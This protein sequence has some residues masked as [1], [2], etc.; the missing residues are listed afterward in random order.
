[1]SDIISKLCSDFL[2]ECYPQLKA[3]H[4]REL[5]A[6]FFGYNSHAALLA[7]KSNSVEFLD[8]AAVLIPDRYT[9]EERRGCLKQ[10]PDNLPTSDAL[11]D[12]LVHFVQTNQLFTGEVWE[13]DDIGEFMIEEYL[14]K[15]LSPELDLEL[16][17]VVS[18][19]NAFFDE[20][21]YDVSTVHETPNRITVT[22]LGTYSGYPVDENEPADDTI[23]ME[24]TVNLRR[25]A[26]HITFE[27]PEVDVEGTVI[28]NI[29]DS[30]QSNEHR[31][32]ADQVPSSKA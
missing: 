23:D 11:V 8:I 32:T 1:M 2:R 26:G 31:V 5:V 4:A 24:I 19:T 17:D 6:A 14:P 13:C 28:H 9:I 10:L 27:E 22:V 30:S 7:D 3:S 25:C 12:D 21:S 29:E 18:S 16:E 20:I 15:H